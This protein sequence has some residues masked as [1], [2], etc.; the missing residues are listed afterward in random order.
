[1]L[2]ILLLYRIQAYGQVNQELMDLPKIIEI[3][4]WGNKVFQSIL[5]LSGIY[6]IICKKFYFIYGSTF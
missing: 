3:F 5:V 6:L 4:T 1:M 2:Y